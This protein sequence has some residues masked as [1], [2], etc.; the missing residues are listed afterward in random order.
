MLANVADLFSHLAAAGDDPVV[1]W[2]RT[3][4]ASTLPTH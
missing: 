2:C 3:W 4:H 1:G